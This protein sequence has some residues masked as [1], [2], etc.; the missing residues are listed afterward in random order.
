M[1]LAENTVFSG[2][3]MLTLVLNSWYKVP[4]VIS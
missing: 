3:L 4:T 1:K 2:F